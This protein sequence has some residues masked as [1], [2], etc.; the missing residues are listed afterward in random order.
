MGDLTIIDMEQRTPPTPT[1]SI[2]EP[3]PYRLPSLDQSYGRSLDQPHQDSED[4][5]LLRPLSPVRLPP[6]DAV[7]DIG[8]LTRPDEFGDA[9][10]ELVEKQFTRIT[11]R[12]A[13]IQ[14]E[15]NRLPIPAPGKD[16]KQ[17]DKAREKYETLQRERDMILDVVA[18]G[19]VIPNDRI[20]SFLHDSAEREVAKKWEQKRKA[21]Q[22]Y[23][24]ARA[25]VAPNDQLSTWASWLPRAQKINPDATM[26]DLRDLWEQKYGIKGAREQ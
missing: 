9:R 22:E 25:Q 2:S 8:L 23:E 5:W 11:R 1:P 19:K 12:L 16:A 15:L 17:Q 7:D 13:Q 26:E 3:R 24:R 21:K 14:A 4:G 10:A 6:R 20:L 18:A